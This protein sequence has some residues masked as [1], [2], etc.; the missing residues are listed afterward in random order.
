MEP[1]KK[2][3]FNIEGFLSDNWIDKLDN[4]HFMMI[5]FDILEVDVEDSENIEAKQMLNAIGI[6]C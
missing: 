6:R 3:I 2:P 4:V 1:N 5:A